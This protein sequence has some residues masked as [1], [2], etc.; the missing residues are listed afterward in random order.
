MDPSNEE[1]KDK[2]STRKTRSRFH[3]GSGWEEWTNTSTKESGIFCEKGSM[4]PR[5]YTCAYLCV[6]VPIHMWRPLRLLVLIESRRRL[7]YPNNSYC[8]KPY[9]THV[10][11]LTVSFIRKF[12]ISDSYRFNPNPSLHSRGVEGNGWVDKPDFRNDVTILSELFYQWLL[13]LRQSTGPWSRL[14]TLNQITFHLH[15]I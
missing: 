8:R 6:C 13:S 5:V 10:L 2:W 11:R 12:V 4:Y 7:Y 3:Q 15:L 9:P 1:Q 14:P